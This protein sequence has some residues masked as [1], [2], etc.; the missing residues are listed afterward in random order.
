MRS[1]LLRQTNNTFKC[2]AVYC[3]K[4]TTHSNAQLFTVTN[5]Q[6]IQMPSCLKCSSFVT[7]GGMFIY[8]WMFKCDNYLNATPKRVI[9]TSYG[10]THLLSKS[11]RQMQ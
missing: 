10:H 9:L 5:K 6:H 3:D 8:H 11:E 7:A 2:A 4:Q 1:C